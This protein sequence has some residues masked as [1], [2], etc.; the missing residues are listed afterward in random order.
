MVAEV[1]GAAVDSN[2]CSH[3]SW[4]AD[5]DGAAACEAV[6]AT[7]DRLREQEWRELALAAQ[8]AVLH[9]PDTRTP[10]LPAVETVP[11][12]AAESAAE[13]A[14]EA[15]EVAVSAGG[16]AG[17]AYRVAAGQANR[18]SA[19]GCGERSVPAGG[20]GHRPDRR[21]RV[22]GAG[23]ADGHRVPH[24][25]LPG[26]R[27][28]GPAAPAP[29]AVA[30]ARRGPGPGLEGPAGGPD[31]ARRAA[32]PRAGPVRGHRDHRLHRLAA[33]VGVHRAGRG[34]DH[35]GRPGRRRDP[36]RG[37][38]DGP[39][40]EHRTLHR[41]RPEDPDRPRR[42]RR[43]DLLRRRLRPDRAD[44]APAGRPR[45]HRR[46]P[47]QGPR[48]PRQ[49]GPRPGPAH[50]TRHHRPPPR[51]PP[52]RR[53]PPRRP[54]PRRPPPRRRR[55]GPRPR[56]RGTRLRPAQCRRPKPAR[57]ARPARP[58]RAAR[59]RRRGALPGLR[60]RGLG[61]RSRGRWAL[62]AGG[63]RAGS[64]R[65]SCGRGRCSTCGSANRRSAPGPAW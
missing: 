65:R 51:R 43:G 3:T 36:P 14:A 34:Q 26:P 27:R 37:R 8:W 32:E 53:P 55:P 24:R 31:G 23:D 4:V 35:R 29:A 30:G 39:V 25:V 11:P 9:D 42:R 46:T 5:L 17:G 19:G 7:Q 22:R 1:P 28:R 59:C 15:A 18:W 56:R 12:T 16:V 10:A 61:R 45:Q 2:T 58:T 44:P 33:L 38:G 20:R 60:P 21:V 54:P 63:G 64:T 50:P 6:T 52:P 13:A 47:L 48:D 62:G 41:A 57:P 49:P 40:R